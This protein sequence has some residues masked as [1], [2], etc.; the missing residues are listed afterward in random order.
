[1]DWLGARTR[2]NIGFRF[3]ILKDSLGLESYQR[4]SM[5]IN[6][7]PLNSLKYRQPWKMRIMIKTVKKF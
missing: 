4:V 5:R 1:M 3:K 7:Q 2:I 6:C